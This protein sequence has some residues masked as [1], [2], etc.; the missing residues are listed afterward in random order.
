[1]GKVIDSVFVRPVSP[2]LPSVPSP[3]PSLIPG[4]RERRRHW[5]VILWEVEK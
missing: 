5:V 3:L 2:H 4:D 1:M